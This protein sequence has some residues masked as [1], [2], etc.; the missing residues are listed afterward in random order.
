MKIKQ[1]AK[2]LIILILMVSVVGC[3]SEEKKETLTSQSTT[4]NQEQEPITNLESYDKGYL[5]VS[6]EDSKGLE[7]KECTRSAT[8]ENNVEVKLNY[9]LYYQGEY[10]KIL[11]SKEEIITD[12]QDVLDEYQTAYINIYKNYED[13]DYYTTS[14]VRENNSVTNDTVINYDKLDTDKL[15][16]IEGEE[17]NIIKDGKVKVSDWLEFAE[18]FGTKCE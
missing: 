7:V 13:L 10:L 1:I 12:D 17:D 5:E 16:E 4:S 15:L 14:V 6:E 11:H 2:L 18:K 8:G 3:G 9:T